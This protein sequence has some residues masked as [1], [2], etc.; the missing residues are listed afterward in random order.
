[1]KGKEKFEKN[2]IHS[3]NEINVIKPR[4]CRLKLH[5]RVNKL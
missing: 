5:V 1:M 3:R 4:R 2:S